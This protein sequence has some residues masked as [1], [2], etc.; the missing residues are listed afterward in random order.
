[1]TGSCSF[2]SRYNQDCCVRQVVYGVKQ[3]YSLVDLDSF[4]SPDLLPKKAERYACCLAVKED[5]TLAQQ[6]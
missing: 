1:M 6:Y 2:T 3:Y 5:L 4:D